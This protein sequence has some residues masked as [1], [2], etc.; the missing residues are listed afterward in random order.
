MHKHA[1]SADCICHNAQLDLPVEPLHSKQNVAC[2]AYVEARMSLVH[3]SK[4]SKSLS[5]LCSALLRGVHQCR[6]PQGK[7]LLVTL[8]FSI[9]PSV[10]RAASSRAKGHSR[11][12]ATVSVAIAFCNNKEA[13]AYMTAGLVADGCVPLNLLRCAG[14]FKV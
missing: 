6:V 12:A 9:S 1:R 4:L 11:N 5:T 14:V 8:R 10:E 3:K 2:M 7:Q 13:P